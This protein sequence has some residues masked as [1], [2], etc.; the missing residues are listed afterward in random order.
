M[1]RHCK[2]CGARTR[3]TGQRW[4]LRRFTI[5]IGTVIERCCP[6]CLK[7]SAERKRNV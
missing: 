2:R 7:R 5:R 6:S 3:R 4:A 1:I